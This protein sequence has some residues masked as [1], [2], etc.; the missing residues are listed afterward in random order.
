VVLAAGGDGAP[1]TLRGIAAHTPAEV[2][3]L[4]AGAG[5]TLE[6]VADALG[7][8]AGTAPPLLLA[9]ELEAGAGFARAVNAASAAA[10]SG[11]VVLLTPGVEVGPS[12]LERLTQAAHCDSTVVS[13]TALED[14]DGPLGVPVGA[15]RARQVPTG[16]PA[17]AAAVAS[18]APRAYPRISS[19]APH[20][21]YLRRELF[22][23]LGE[24]D[25]A[26][27]EPIATVAELSRR[28]LELGMLHVAADDVFV[29]R[30]SARGPAGGEPPGPE[31]AD[32]RTVL[33]RCL[34][35]ARAALQGVS[36][37][38][39]ARALGP[40]VGGTQS[41][42]AELILALASDERLCVR[43]VVPPDLPE[44]LASRL[45]AV[46]EL[47]VITYEQAAAG[48]ARTDVVHRPQQ[49]FS[50][51]D[52]TL[53]H[54]L[55]ERIV[56]GQQDLIAYRNPAYHE[57]LGHW[58]SY[59]RVTRLA[60]TVADRVVFFSEHAKRDAQSEDLVADERGDVGGI[61][62]D[63]L[64]VSPAPAEPDV[65]AG[66]P[67]DREL[68]VCL[69]ADYKHKNRP[70]ALALLG[71]L[72]ERHGWEGCLVLAGAHVPYGSSRDE[73]AALLARD[74]ELARHVVD[75]G[76]VEEAVKQWLYQR[77][78]AV[79]YPTLYEG[80]GLVP[81]EAAR[82][83]TPCLYAPR[84][85][86]LELAGPDA[87][88]LIPWDA[89]LSSDSVVRLLDEG[90]ER[91]HH[92]RLLADGMAQARWSDVVARL[93]ETYRGAIRAPY[94][95][96]APRAWQELERERLIATLARNAENN[97]RAYN[98]LR[99]SVGIGLPLVAEDGMLTRD[100]QRGLMRVA[101]RGPLRTLL[102]SPF[103]A[104]GRLG[105]A[106]A[107][108]APEPRSQER[109]DAAREEQAGRDDAGARW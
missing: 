104:L 75:L 12:W 50:E 105:G 38:V 10:G 81:F 32:E 87:A 29:T 53:L 91:E 19:A 26:L 43:A 61:G 63:V 39:D 82:A 45:Q 59:R 42:T 57:T 86:L 78:R 74:P 55:G 56:I 72:R 8:E 31:G 96:A 109:A 64:D 97:N 13:A 40:R 24:L 2:P 66:V 58:H 95:A 18:L 83:G 52:L 84:A 25:P 20:C 15:W 107:S 106:R 89:R 92:L 36:V 101:S 85:S 54:M 22:D 35:C 60:L 17:A 5:E 108:A 14:G 46:P 33:R 27:A 69:G 71:A 100:E 28:A 77:A 21:V 9:L 80:F 34:G 23:R 16:Q 103:G 3:V 6:R 62:A 94:R 51:E 99:A 90:A 93:L 102:L 65:P 47:E 67:V 70:F 76:P 30:S 37:T 49:V 41:Y 7:S 68:L 4:L 88:T 11:D 98:D 73:E 44:P 1:D 79:V 48:V